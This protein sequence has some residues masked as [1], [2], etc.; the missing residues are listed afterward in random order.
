LTS[1]KGLKVLLGSGR[2]D[3]EPAIWYDKFN[4]AAGSEAKSLSINGSFRVTRVLLRCHLSMEEVL[5]NES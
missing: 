1:L 4:K 2:F 3:G 5:E